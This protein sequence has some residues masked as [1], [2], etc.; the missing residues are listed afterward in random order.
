MGHIKK[1]IL[2]SG[3]TSVLLSGI[4][5][6]TIMFTIQAAIAIIGGQENSSWK[7]RTCE[8]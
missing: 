5:I 6:L 2:A 1:W 8:L 7:L 3:I 4:L